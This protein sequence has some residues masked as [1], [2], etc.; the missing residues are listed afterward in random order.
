M[1]RTYV[2]NNHTK[3][4]DF[5][6][7]AEF[8]YNNDYQDSTKMSPFEVLYGWRC[9]TPVTWDSPVDWLMLGLDLLMDM[10]HLV[11]KVQVNLKE[12][13]DC[14]KIYGDQNRKDKHF[15]IDDHVYLKVKSKRSSLSLGR[16]GKLAPIFFE[17]FEILTKK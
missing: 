13:Q 10:E 5:L 8:A 1:L 3:W 17:P 12:E 15:Q 4:E 6:H 11:T 16:C 9:R 7:L 14:Q 2:M